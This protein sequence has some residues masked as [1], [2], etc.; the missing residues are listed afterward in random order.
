MVPDCADTGSS[1]VENVFWPEGGSIPGEYRAFVV[2]YEGSC[3]GPGTYELELKIGG[4]VV[5]SDTRT[6]SVGEQSTP[7]TAD[8]G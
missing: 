2:H 5:A 7:I 6:L 1:N 3:G 4:V 8:G